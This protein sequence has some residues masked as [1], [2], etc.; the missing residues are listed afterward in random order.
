[1]CVFKC[2]SVCIRFA[3]GFVW[4]RVRV[5]VCGHM[6][7]RISFFMCVD[8]CMYRIQ[9]CLYIRSEHEKIPMLCTYN[10]SLCMTK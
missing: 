9:G 4:A 1:M 10:Y 8:E 6:D 5:C 3:Y 7:G 2:A